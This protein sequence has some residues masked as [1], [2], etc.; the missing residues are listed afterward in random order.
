[1][2]LE[3]R[4]VV[5]T[6]RILFYVS[7]CKFVQRFIVNRVLNIIGVQLI[8]NRALEARH[9]RSPANVIYAMMLFM[10]VS[11]C[12]I[13]CLAMTIT[14]RFEIGE[15]YLSARKPARTIANNSGASSFSFRQA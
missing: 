10:C 13:K 7:T 9:P 4:N 11:L 1:M 14:L 2:L 12:L 15:K 3:G 5:I 6:V 8:I